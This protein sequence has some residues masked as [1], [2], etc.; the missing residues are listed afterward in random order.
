[1]VNVNFSSDEIFDDSHDF[2]LEKTT[3]ILDYIIENLN[4]SYGK[5]Q[6]ANNKKMIAEASLPML[7]YLVK[8]LISEIENLEEE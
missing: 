1:L 5:E 2:M 7:M 3:E 6:A 4:S 8:D